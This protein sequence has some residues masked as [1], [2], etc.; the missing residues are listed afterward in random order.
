MKTLRYLFIPLTV[1]IPSAFGQI[2]Y[3]EGFDSEES[4]KVEEQATS[5]A[6]VRY[7]DYANLT[8]GAEQFELPEAP[9]Q[10]EGSAPTRGVFFQMNLSAGAPNA[11]NLFAADGPGGNVI[12]FS[13]NYRLTYDAYISVATPIPSGGTEQI[14][15][16]LGLDDQIHARHLREGAEPLQGIWGWTAGENGYRSED[17]TIYDGES[18]LEQK[19]DGDSGALWGRAYPTGLPRGAWVQVQ[20]EVVKNE[21]RVFY[22]E[23]L[24]HSVAVPEAVSQ[25]RVMFGY[26][27][28]FGSISGAQDF[29]WG[30]I[31]NVQV[32]TVVLDVRQLAGFE[33]VLLPGGNALERY[34]LENLRDTPITLTEAVF[35]GDD[36]GVF[37]AVT[38]FPLTIAPNSTEM[39]EIAFTPSNE[40]DG[41]IAAAVTLSSD[42]P[43]VRP[44][45]LDLEA[46]RYRELLA[47][48]RM[49]DAGNPP[50]DAS[51]NGATGVYQEFRIVPEYES[52]SLVGGDGTSVGFSD[53]HEDGTGNWAQFDVFHSPS[54]TLSVWIQS[55][56]SGTTDVI[57]N[58]NDAA[59]FADN[60]GIYG[61][62]LTEDGEIVVNVR[63]N[64]ILSSGED[65]ISEGQPHHIV[66]THLDEDGFGNETASRSRLYI[67][68]VLV[69]EATGADTF[70]FGDYPDTAR[71][72]DLHLGSRPAAGSGYNGLIDELQIYR[73]ELEPRQ[74]EALFNTPEMTARF[75][76][77]NLAAVS[78]LQF[79]DVSEV[80]ARSL[81]LVLAN[82]GDSEILTITSATL[83]GPDAASYAITDAPESLQPGESV[84]L[85]VTVDPGNRVGGF[86]ATLEIITNDE[87]DPSIVIPLSASVPNPSGL[88][89]HYPMDETEGEIMT[90]A[91]GNRLDGRYVTSDSG[92]VTLGESGL[93][94]GTAARLNERDGVA[95]AEIPGG[96]DLP[97]LPEY[98]IAMWF[99]LDN[100][101]LDTGSVLF[102][103]GAEFQASSA[104]ALLVTPDEAPLQW[105][106][107]QD[108]AIATSSGL[109]KP[110]TLYHLVATYVDSNGV[111][112]GADRLRLY[113]NGELA[114]ELA[115]L[116]VAIEPKAGPTFRF[117]G[118]PGTSGITGVIDDIQLYSRELTAED[119]TFLF[120]NPGTAIGGP[121]EPE[122]DTDTD[123]DGLT[124][125]QEAELGTDPNATDTDG[126]GFSDSQEVAA[127][128]DPL[129]AASRLEMVGVTSA[130]DQRTVTWQSQTG[131]TY[132][133]EV[134]QDLQTWT[135]LADEVAGEDGTTSVNDA[136]AA[137][138][139]Y[140]R[141]S[142]K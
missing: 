116:E 13:G 72:T 73:V 45:S 84:E 50:Q 123:G 58:R 124:D 60:D 7:V 111:E 9:N 139:S 28:A 74:V 133:I 36:A 3:T 51:P 141:A 113:V 87:S 54:V 62:V 10:L 35:A 78:R 14:L 42:D 83:S 37:T 126:D 85:I 71:A 17:S 105:I 109:I 91:S 8:V 52:P 86:L 57:L 130:D 88:L 21:A 90:D 25:G 97:E 64:L 94:G 110:D 107:N 137:G 59:S 115:P 135:P 6:I 93:A 29:Q 103:R 56:G 47:H 39:L 19:A 68:G 67:D 134:S 114:E 27:D 81:P 108:D 119:V 63:D 31:D 46:E 132:L 12:E 34:Q 1:L 53:E 125:A 44:V 98:S 33:P 79:D 77:P 15:W 99:M 48:F 104:I 76:N 38:E 140:Y 18:L 82:S 118:F 49:D 55:G 117:G 30:I 23:V 66:F 41:R 32:E 96:S 5:D 100:A 122:P 16:G 131:V 24:F 142:V 128:T 4:A 102:A 70:G 61:V 136:N 121:T 138:T 26:E 69:D 127:K 89:A 22:N 80:E 11:A 20:V 43:L 112:E 92:I 120:D 129:S 75:D 95:L 40:T 65:A 106:T 101:D 2:L